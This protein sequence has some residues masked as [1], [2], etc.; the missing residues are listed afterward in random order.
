MH[1][2]YVE[3]QNFRKLVSCRVE[4]SEDTT[5]FVGANNSGKTSAMDALRKFL[6]RKNKFT[7]NDFTLSHWEKINEIGR[8]WEEG[9][10]DFELPLSERWSECL[11][12]LDVWL[13]VNDTEIH[14]V[15]HLIPT[16][17]WEGGLLG[18]RLR[19][20]PGN[21]EQLYKEYRIS[22]IAAIETIK[23]ANI[24]QINERPLKLWPKDMHDFLSRKLESHFTIQAYILDP[25]KCIEPTKGIANAQIIPED[26]GQIDGDPFKGLILIN[27]INAQRGF[28]DVDTGKASVES[29]DFT[30]TNG[31]LS[32]QLRSYYNHHLNPSEYPD[33]SDIQALQAIEN[34]QYS[35]DEKL[36]KG[37][38][39]AKK[40]LES[41]GYPGFN[42]PKITI[43]TKIQPMDGLN[44]NSAVR[45]ELLGGNAESINI[46]LSLPEQYNGLGY[47]NLISMVFK[48]MSFRDDWMQ[49]GKVGKRKSIDKEDVILPPIHLVLIEEPEAH[50]HAQVQQVFIRKA[51]DI[52]NKHENLRNQK[53]LKTQMVV[54]T[55]SSHIAHEMKFSSLRYFRRKPAGSLNEVPTSTVV[56]LSEVFGPEEETDKFVTRYLKTTHC[57]LFFAD[58]AILVEGPA[59][60]MLVP[61][62]IRRN[63]KKLNESYVSLLEI[64]GSH[65]HRLRPL[66]EHLGLTSLIITDLDSIKPKG[67]GTNAIHPRRRQKFRTGNNTLKTWVPEKEEIDLLLDMDDAGKTKYYDDFFSIRVAYQCPVL[68]ELNAIC[69]K[70]EA[71]SN[72]FEDAIV[73]NNIS[74][75]KTIEGDGIINSFKNTVNRASTATELGLSIF[76]LLKSV[77][78][79]EFALDLLLLKENDSL[80]VPTYIN[81]GLV[82]LQNELQKKHQD[83]VVQTVEQKNEVLI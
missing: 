62:F 12:S 72:T 43:S 10:D 1:I 45:F 8:M 34:A 51:Y 64:G 80:N 70:E 50:L 66:I 17:D 77:K 53:L 47:Q 39:N 59:E 49:V 78:K 46:P 40:E 16:L 13:Q 61:H 29:G 54:S 56:N 4:F 48:L 25:S 75:F 27:I 38:E 44:H 19:L 5:L 42:D 15:S 26:R 36:L 67:K 35:F 33:S 81:E 41:L 82:W 21:F 6:I 76:N 79:A 18:V 2:K 73:F 14:H 60:R 65:A 32:S 11:P 7:A 63:F 83:F 3:I 71:L 37:F 20:E 69:G 30:N 74:L 9:D 68:V 58:A 28:T 55:H 52:L 24:S 23:S 22:R 31:N 57:D